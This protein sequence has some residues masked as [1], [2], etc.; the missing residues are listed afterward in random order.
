MWCSV[1]FYCHRS[2]ISTS[3]LTYLEPQSAF[4]DKLL[5]F[6]VSYLQNGIA[7]LK[8]L[9]IVRLWADGSS[10][11]PPRVEAVSGLVRQ[12]NFVPS[13]WFREDGREASKLATGGG[14]GGVLIFVACLSHLT[15]YHAF[16]SRRSTFEAEHLS[17]RTTGGGGRISTL[18]ATA[19]AKQTKPINSD[20]L[21]VQ[22]EPAVP[23]WYTLRRTQRKRNN[24]ILEATRPI[25]FRRICKCS[26]C[27]GD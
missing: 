23:P 17:R 16:L 13:R 9:K 7:V 4:G 14:G 21:R 20:P 8:G 6:Q 1:V 19:V 10:S 27:A 18:G 2:L 12:Q 11:A 25:M 3:A 15:I 26:T 24:K 22:V 5:K